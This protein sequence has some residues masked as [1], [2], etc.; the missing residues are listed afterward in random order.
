MSSTT[1]IK[2]QNTQAEACN[3]VMDDSV[4][5]GL[6]VGCAGGGGGGV[7]GA[8]HF[9]RQQNGQYSIIQ[10]CHLYIGRI[11]KQCTSSVNAHLCTALKHETS[12]TCTLSV[13][14]AIPSLK[15]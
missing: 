3:N 9:Y 6:S 4:H 14:Q 10:S 5:V 8:S 1:T 12:I 7:E 2:I 13:V 15:T 11:T